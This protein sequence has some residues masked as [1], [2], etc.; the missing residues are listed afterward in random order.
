MAK[1]LFITWR[2][3]VNTDRLKLLITSAE[4]GSLTKAGKE[5]GY[6]QSAM[7]QMVKHLE[8]E[9]GFPLL[10][11]TNKGVELTKEAR[12]LLP[13]MRQLLRDEEIFKQEVSEIRGIHKGTIRI[14]SFIST[15]M[16]WLPSVL[17]FF[18]NNYPEVIISIEECGEEEMIEGL[19]SRSMDI[20]LMADPKLPDI[21]FIPLYEDPMVVAFTPD[22]Y[23]LRGYTSVPLEDIRDVPFLLTEAT[24]DKDARQTFINAG[25]EP[26]VKFTSKND[27]A[28]MSMVQ[29]GI[30][31]A[32]L[33]ELVI[34]GY[35]GNYEYR[36][37]EPEYY[38]TLGIGVMSERNSGPL[39]RFLID[40]L[41][42]NVRKQ[43]GSEI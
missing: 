36:L 29:R 37:L 40:F 2:Y 20:A 6:S 42:D 10:I 31:I 33:P 28:V 17:E 11:R 3:R 32:I 9:V 15:S 4:Y 30:G 24:Y 38:R 39:A 16:H 25:I 41:T 19:R 22:Y 23:D 43:T 5:L 26:N 12:M 27:F 21:E 34:D 7:T 14:G 1:I 8:D 13:T 35:E 18:Q